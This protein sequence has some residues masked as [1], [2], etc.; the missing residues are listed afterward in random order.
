[1]ITGGVT[2]NR[3]KLRDVL[4]YNPETNAWKELAGLPEA[5]SSAVAGVIAGKLYV[6]TGNNQGPL[7]TT[8]VG[9]WG[10]D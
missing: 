4:V 3:R 2:Q 7:D 9:A 1:M 5:R 8:F 10:A 6:T